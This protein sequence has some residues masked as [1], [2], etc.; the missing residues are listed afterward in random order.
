LG[1]RRGGGTELKW[2]LARGAGWAAGW[3]QE[4]AAKK[5]ALRATK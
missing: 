1:R 5:A 4:M 3:E 2:G